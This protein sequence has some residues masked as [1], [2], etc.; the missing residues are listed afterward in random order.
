MQYVSIKK[1]TKNDGETVFLV[2][3][4][5]LKNSQGTAKQVIPHPFG[6]NYLE[7]QTLEDAI[8]AI[9]LTGFKHILPDGTK[10]KTDAKPDM[11][12]ESYD[13]QVYEALLKQTQDMNSAVVSAAITALGEFRDFKLLNLFFDKMG[14]DNDII[15]SAAI[16]SVLM[17]G[18][19]AIK[20]LLRILH[21]ENWVKR[22][23]AMICISRLIDSESVNP[24][25]LFSSLIEMTNDK[26]H[27]VKISAITALG[28]AY[29][30]Y[31]KESK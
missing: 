18:S 9:E 16:N 19:S 17:F 31:S 20:E 5:T 21:D 26:N 13:E 28:K 25:R 4:L 30:L 1:H 14:E 6:D 15:R 10:Q 24:E 22:N 27:I 29:K 11:K 3:A 7:F 23:S 12:A 8:K 2:Q